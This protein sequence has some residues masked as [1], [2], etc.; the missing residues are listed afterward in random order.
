[1]RFTLIELLVVIAIIAIL[2][3]L[4]LPALSKARERARRVVCQNSLKQAVVGTMMY[5]DD[6]D[7]VFPHSMG[8]CGD[9]H[10]EWQNNYWSSTPP[11]PV[12]GRNFNW[13][14][15]QWPSALGFSAWGR[16]DWLMAY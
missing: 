7:G 15:Q 4:L 1:M 5:R 6:A 16:M 8:I 12:N 14:W 11:P 2:A 13:H 10:V 9:G 3:S